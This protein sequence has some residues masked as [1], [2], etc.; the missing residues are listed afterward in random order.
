[1]ENSEDE[2]RRTK[3][4][5]L[6]KKAINASTKF[7]HSLK[8][9]PRRKHVIKDVRDVE[10]QASVDNF[11]QALIAEDPLPPRHDDYHVMLR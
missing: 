11:R 10:E 3:I 9:K 7:R 1:M 4:G 5:A 6:K 2:R 8:K